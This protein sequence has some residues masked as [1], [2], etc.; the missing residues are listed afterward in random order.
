MSAATGSVRCRFSDVQPQTGIPYSRT[1]FV[2]LPGFAAAV[3]RRQDLC[4][5][6][7]DELV[8]MGET[9]DFIDPAEHWEVG[10]AEAAAACQPDIDTIGVIG[11]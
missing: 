7:W 3:V 4:S 1:L 5:G 2:D 9:E 6:E 10:P 11:W 8:K